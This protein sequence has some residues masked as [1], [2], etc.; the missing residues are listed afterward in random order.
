M[1]NLETTSQ[2]R[3]M[4]LLSIDGGGLA[5]LIPA[6]SLVEIEAQLDALTGE[7]RPLCERFNLIGGTSTG[8]ILAAGLAL[9]LKA[10]QLRDFYLRFGKDIFSK[11]FWPERLWHNYP[12]APLE[13]HLK[14]VYGEATTLGGENLKTSILNRSEECDPRHY[15]VFYQ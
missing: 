2:S 7:S 5:G 9:G 13:K 15:L 6:E 14:D 3:P 1:S 12:S 8:A 4:R 11:V 10:G